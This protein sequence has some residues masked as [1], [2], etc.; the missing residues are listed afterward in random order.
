VPPTFGYLVGRM[1]G[2]WHRDVMITREEIRGLMAGL[3]AVDS[4]PVGHTRLTTWARQHADALGRRYAS[5]LARR[6]NREGAYE[7]L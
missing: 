3:L 2:A 1:L 4:P 5:E 7:R 6:A